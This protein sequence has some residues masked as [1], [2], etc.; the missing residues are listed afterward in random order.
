MTK[1]WEIGRL[2]V[3]ICAYLRITLSYRVVIL[4]CLGFFLFYIIGVGGGAIDT[5]HQLILILI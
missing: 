3:R 4:V 2:R 1:N 5:S